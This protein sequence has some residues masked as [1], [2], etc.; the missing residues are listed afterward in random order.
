MADPTVLVP[1]LS[2]ALLGAYYT[3]AFV[4]HAP[5][6]PTPTLLGG[7]LVVAASAAT[8]AM[9]PAAEAAPLIGYLGCGLAVILMASPLATMATVLREKSTAAMPFVTSLVC[10]HVHVQL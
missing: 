7:G 2:G 6:L 4:A 9:L 3:K 5:T 10:G 8:A 1:N